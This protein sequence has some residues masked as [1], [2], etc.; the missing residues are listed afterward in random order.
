M[1]AFKAF[2]TEDR[3]NNQLLSLGNHTG[4]DCALHPSSVELGYNLG[5]LAEEA[6]SALGP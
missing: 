6:C 1:E 2:G 5:A 3:Y 4:K